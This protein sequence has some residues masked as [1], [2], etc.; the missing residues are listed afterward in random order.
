MPIAKNFRRHDAGKAQQ[1][2]RSD[3]GL[4][5]PGH[6]VGLLQKRVQTHNCLTELFL[7]LWTA[8]LAS[9]AG[10]RH[11]DLAGWEQAPT[12][13]LKGILYFDKYWIGATY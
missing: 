5:V 6:G 7:K 2:E 3:P 9:Q 10:C 4:G 11:Q 13:L 8:A 1:L 12:G